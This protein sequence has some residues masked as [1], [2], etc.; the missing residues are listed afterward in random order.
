M[1]AQHT[2]EVEDASI[3]YPSTSSTIPPLPTSA[4]I[5]PR[6][7]SAPS[8]MLSASTSPTFEPAVPEV[9]HLGRTIVS[10]A[11]TRQL[12]AWR[13]S[14][15]HNIQGSDILQADP[16]FLHDDTGDFGNAY[17]IDSDGN[18]LTEDLDPHRSF[19]DS[20]YRKIYRDSARHEA[21][22]DKMKR[23]K[24]CYDKGV[25]YRGAETGKNTTACRQLKRV[26]LSDQPSKLSP[27]T[28]FSSY[29][30]SDESLSVSDDSADDE[31]DARE[32][33][34]RAKGNPTCPIQSP[35]PS[36]SSPPTRTDTNAELGSQMLEQ[37]TY[38]DLAFYEDDEGFDEYYELPDEDSDEESK[39]EDDPERAAQ[40]AAQRAAVVSSPTPTDANSELGSPMLEPALYEDLASYEDNEGFD[41][42][43]E[44]P[45]EF[46]DEEYKEE[47]APEWAAQRAA[48]AHRVCVLGTIWEEE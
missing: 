30:H 41:E 47:Y 28:Q 7:P 35:L 32:Y 27:P 46:S 1:D 6:A 31:I 4:T 26:S 12:P 45:D 40:R 22:N 24:Q 48:V 29:T 11:H 17:A 21:M 42:Y 38:E 44:L 43:Y 15:S 19:L 33:D 8:T 34:K 23:I 25:V 20:V 3:S 10:H 18:R 39:E 16:L 9:W 36:F 13:T 37:A 5:H 14:S 2:I